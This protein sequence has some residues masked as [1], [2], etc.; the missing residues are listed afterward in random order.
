[1]TTQPEN[2][3]SSISDNTPHPSDDSGAHP[4]GHATDVPLSDEGKQDAT[5]L[6]EPFAV[7]IVGPGDSANPFFDAPN[8]ERRDEPPPAEQPLFQSWNEPEFHSPV[9]TP[10][11][12]HVVILAVFTLSGLFCAT[13]LIR[14]ALHFHLFG[15]SSLQKA[16][17]DVHYTLGSEAILYLITLLACLLFFPLIWHKGFFAGVQW[18]GA[19]AFKLRLRLF[20]IASVCFSLALINGVLLPGP[21][22]A[23]IDKIFRTP[24]AAWILF[25]FGVTLAPFFE[26]LV[27]RG[28]LLPAFCTA[29]DWINE[30]ATH[31][32]I[33]PLDENGQ[34]R[35]SLG[36]MITASI[37]ISIPFAGMHAA[38]TG[39][40][41]GPFL[42]LIGV[43][44]VLCWA[45]LSTRSLAASV[46]VHAS[47]N[48]FLFFFMMVGTSGFR[49]LDKM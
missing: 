47:Y 17:T 33:R 22:D 6:P 2:E 49:H 1:M 43:S 19:I 15:I 48:F 18:N 36:A 24:G 23:P 25:A 28:F 32:P 31:A 40:S 27:F 44:L 45:R 42:L 5:P 10:H 8:A 37:F 20:I 35:W 12:G 3:F 39:Y 13:L 29:F 41:W 14:S 30:K 4:N 34:P 26:E 7:P 11:L 38:Q 46:M 9:R 21:D 16:V